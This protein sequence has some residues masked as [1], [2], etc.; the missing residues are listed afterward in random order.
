MDL[1]PYSVHKLRPAIPVNLPYSSKHTAERLFTVKTRYNVIRYNEILAIVEILVCH[2]YFPILITEII[3]QRNRT[4][5]KLNSV[6]S[7]N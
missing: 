7:K 6:I 4:D 1:S 3:L 2:T 5:F